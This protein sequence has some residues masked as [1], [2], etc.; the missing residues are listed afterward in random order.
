[1]LGIGFEDF[2]IALGGRGQHA[3]LFKFIKLQPDGIG[4]IAK[5]GFQI[6]Q[7]ALGTAVQ[8]ELQQELDAGFGSDEGV[9][10][11]LVDG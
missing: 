5:L 10:H 4:T 3:C 9:E 7:I 2:F 1:M 11:G 6:T 8:K